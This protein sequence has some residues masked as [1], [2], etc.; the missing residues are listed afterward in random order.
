MAARTQARTQDDASTREKN[1]GGGPVHVRGTRLRRRF[2]P[3]DRHARRREPGPDHLLLR[4][5][6]RALARGRRPRVRRPE[7]GRGPRRDR[8]RVADL[9]ARAVRP[10]D[11]PVHPLRGRAPR[12][13]AAD[14]RGRQAR[15]PAH[16][17]DR[18]PPRQADLGGHARTVDPPRGARARA[19]ARRPGPLPL[20]LHRSRQ[21]VLH[22]GA[23][24]PPRER[25]RPLR[26]EQRRKAR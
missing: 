26:T 5:Q 14:E 4:L 24:V 25:L 16:A 13:P 9:V 20:H 18:R 11:P 1:R 12:V 8:G 2:D 21:R 23:R 17:L 15:Q 22:A 3:R 6:G 19:R 10:A 7:R